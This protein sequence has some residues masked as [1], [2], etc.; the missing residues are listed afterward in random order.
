MRNAFLDPEAVARWAELFYPNTPKP[1]AET[2]TGRERMRAYHCA[3]GEFADAF[4]RT[5]LWT[6]FVLRWYTK[7]SASA[8]LAVFSGV[9]T[10]EAANYFRRLA[11]VKIVP[12]K[13]WAELHPVV[14][15]LSLIAKRRNDILHHGA[16]DVAEGIGSVS[17]EALALTVDRVQSFP[18]SP[19]ILADMTADLRK[20]DAHF[21]LRHMGRPALRGKHPELE[22]VLASAWRYKPPE[23][24]RT[25]TSPA[26]K[27]RTRRPRR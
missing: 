16:R 14:D 10:N 4:A 20:I 8:A 13:D 21:L 19:E 2:D 11:E 26:P 18:I 24:S 23:Q 9:R 5:E 6:H 7:T 25:Q 1:A 22:R 15:Q 3:L 27:S 17:N 12:P